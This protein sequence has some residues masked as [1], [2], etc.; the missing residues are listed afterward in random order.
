MQ[1]TIIKLNTGDK[2]LW[3]SLNDSI[4]SP[5]RLFNKLMADTNYNYLRVKDILRYQYRVFIV[6]VK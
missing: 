1:R 2:L 6:I 4:R 5:H 3:E